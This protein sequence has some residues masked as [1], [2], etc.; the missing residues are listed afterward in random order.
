VLSSARNRARRRWDVR[1]EASGDADVTEELELTGQA[2]PEWR[3]HYQTAGERMDRYAKVWT[4]RNPGAHLLSVDMPSIEDRNRPVLVKARATVPRLAEPTAD[5]GLLL[6]VGAREADLV[7]TYARLSQRR[8]DLVLG[9]PWQHDEAITYRLP[10]GQRAAWLPPRR[11]IDSRF[12]SFE[13][14]VERQGPTIVRTRARLDVTRERVP[15]AAYPEFRRF[16][17]DVDAALGERVVVTAAPIDEPAN[18]SPAPALLQS[19]G[20]R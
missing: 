17:A 14:E 6:P 13:L 7:R 10:V 11:R 19:Q 2:A 9:Y 12:G 5:G 4:G 16:L 3:E 18:V 20:P 1:L 8:S 15:A